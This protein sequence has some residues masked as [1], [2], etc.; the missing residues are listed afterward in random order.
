MAEKGGRGMVLYGLRVESQNWGCYEGVRA[1]GVN[2]AG[3]RRR[4][5]ESGARERLVFTRFEGYFSGKMVTTLE[6]RGEICKI[7]EMRRKP[8]FHGE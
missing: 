4:M 8:C 2:G 6:L 3:G 1:C 7:K 5:L